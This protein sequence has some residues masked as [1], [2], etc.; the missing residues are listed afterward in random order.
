MGKLRE[1]KYKT[2][3]R[4]KR[5]MDQNLTVGKKNVLVVPEDM[6]DRENFVYMIVNED[7]GN[8]EYHESL[9]YDTV[10]NMP[11]VVVGD[12]DAAKAKQD[13]SVVRISVGGGKSA[14]LMSK[15][16]KWYN[17]DKAAE[18]KRLQEMDKQ[19][20]ADNKQKYEEFT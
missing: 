4:A 5:R 11:D 17:E 13:G 12:D 9:D 15:P 6:L 16:K 7:P 8:V 10:R 2:V 19:M 18:E 3:S 14:V 20:E 1:K